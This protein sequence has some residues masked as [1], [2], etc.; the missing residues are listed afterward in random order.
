LHALTEAGAFAGRTE[1]L[2]LVMEFHPPE[3]VQALFVGLLRASGEMAYHF[4]ATLTA[5]HGVVDSRYDWSLRPLYLAF[6]TDDVGS[7]REAFLALCATLKVDGAAQLEVVD[8][9]IAVD[10]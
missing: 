7:R 8:R 6:N 9:A 2:D 10:H 3:V 1:T 4:A 5:I